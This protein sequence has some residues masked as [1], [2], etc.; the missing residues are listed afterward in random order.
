MAVDLESYLEA[1]D[2]ENVCG[3]DLEY[4]ADFIALEQ[5]IKGKPEQQVGDTIQE[6]EPPNWREIRK[7]AEQLLTRTRDLRV[8]ISLLRAL[9]ATE[10]FA[11]FN[12]GIS[13]I[14]ALVEQRWD[15]IY[16]QLDPDDDNDPTERVN[17]LMSLCD[18]ETILRPLQQTPLIES[19]GLGR[20]NLRDVSIA[21]GKITVAN[22]DS[23]ISSSTI[24][25]A[26][27]DSDPENLQHTFEA[28]SAGLDSLNG[29]ERFVTE[30]VGINDAPNFGDLRN[31]L[32]ESRALLTDWLATRGGVETVVTDEAESANDDDAGKAVP[33]A[34]EKKSAPGAINDTR[35][36]LNA[37]NLVC[38]YYKKNEPS[39]PVPIFIE[40]GMR[41]V[42]K[43]FMEALKDIAPDG[44]DQANVIRGIRD[45]DEY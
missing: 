4:D 18:H 34:A 39:S 9:I 7:S 3:D 30:Q 33:V 25:A 42:G 19:K 21:T 32:K 23:G 28:I 24:D 2:P 31:L 37:L 14:K 10:G 27:Q 16:P 44:L 22:N 40:R 12:D 13:L 11:G 45:E 5:A 41:L 29:L 43:S 38:E 20:F 15:S 17:I 1:I 36:V 26:V 6:A 35:D 8:L